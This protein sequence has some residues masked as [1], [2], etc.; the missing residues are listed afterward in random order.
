MSGDVPAV[1]EAVD[2]ILSCKV[3]LE[4]PRG[5]AKHQPAVLDVKG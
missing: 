3:Q 2:S 5:Q 4:Q 1:Q